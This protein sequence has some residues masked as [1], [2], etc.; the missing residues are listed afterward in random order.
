MNDCVT[1]DL[2]ATYLNGDIY[3]SIGRKSMG[4]GTSS[5]CLVG[6]SQLKMSYEPCFAI[7]TR[8]LQ[9]NAVLHMIQSVYKHPLASQMGK[10]SWGTSLPK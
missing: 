10:G 3:D 7:T 8:H 5:D 1:S 6:D 2:S 9:Q 4:I